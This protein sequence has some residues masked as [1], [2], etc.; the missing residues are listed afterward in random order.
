MRLLCLLLLAAAARA[1]LPLPGGPGP[2]TGES[3]LAPGDTGWSA[4]R[5]IVTSPLL[6][7]NWADFPSLA[8][9]SDGQLWAQWFQRPPG[10][11]TGYGYSGWFA[12]SIDAGTSW[13]KPAP[14]GQEFVALAPQSGGRMLAVWLESTRNSAGH[15]PREADAPYAPAMRLMARLLAPDGSALHDWLIDGDVCTCCQNTLAC[16]PGDRALVG[17]RGHRP[18]ET[19]DTGLALFDGRTWSTPRT[20]HADGWKIPACPVNGPAADAHGD[21]VA[22]A[23][24]TAAGGLARVQAKFSSDAGDTF[25]RALPVDLGRPLGRLDLLMLPDGSALVS[26][27]ET[28]GETHAAGLHLRR[29]WPDGRASAPL[30]VA[31]TSAVRASGFP[32]LALR[33]GDDFPVVVSWTDA[34]PADPNNPKSPSTSRV[35]TAQVSA[36]NLQPSAQP[37]PA[38]TTPATAVIPHERL[39][40]IELCSATPAQP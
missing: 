38:P 2:D 20:L 13:S 19:R 17:Y 26:W 21:A 18:D 29:L 15:R 23:W 16:L 27:L 6:M 14:L 10:D 36:Q 32:R 24:F 25:G 7:E 40:F 39:Q 31:A 12:R 30:L 34:S 11:D 1:A 28:K 37:W 8:V 33:P 22:I 4:P 3:S 35:L 9:G 5:T